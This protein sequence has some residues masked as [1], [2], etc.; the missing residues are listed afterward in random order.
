MTEDLCDKVKS[1]CPG[2][3]WRPGLKQEGD[4]KIA[5]GKL[6]SGLQVLTLLGSWLGWGVLGGQATS[7]A[8]GFL[9]TTCRELGWWSLISFWI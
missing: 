5:V 7:L 2:S 8:P 4:V 1:C 6:V 3:A 9:V